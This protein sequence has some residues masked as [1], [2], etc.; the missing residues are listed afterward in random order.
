[1]PCQE[2]DESGGRTRKL[3]KLKLPPILPRL[4]Q[5]KSS[6]KGE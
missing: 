3:A 2:H 4:L 5:I 6:E 1:M